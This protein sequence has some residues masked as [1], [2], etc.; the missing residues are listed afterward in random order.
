ML[1]SAQQ[2]RRI[3]AAAAKSIGVTPLAVLSR[4]QHKMRAR[5]RAI[6]MMLSR[7]RT[8]LSLTELGQIFMRDHSTVL[9]GIRRAEKS[10]KADPAWAAH[11]AQIVTELDGE[12]RRVRLATTVPAI[13]YRVA[14]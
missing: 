5:A 13:R 14:I 10:V 6:A 1:N 3:L 11:H 2:V 4:D 7:A 12:D 9:H 8:E